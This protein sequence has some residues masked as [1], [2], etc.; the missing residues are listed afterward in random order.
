MV[1]C[2]VIEV[3]LCNILYPGLHNT[4]AHYTGQQQ[5]VKHCINVGQQLF[6]A[7]LGGNVA[8]VSLYLSFLNLVTTV[9]LDYLVFKM[10][11]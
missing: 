6:F 3:G 1:S 8:T 9:F 7:I 11:L 5:N 10:A 2:N 4:T